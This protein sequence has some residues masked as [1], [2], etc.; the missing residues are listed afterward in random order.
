MQKQKYIFKQVM[1]LGAFLAL[2]VLA[3]LSYSYFTKAQVPDFVNY[4]GRL[5]DSSGNP[6][7]TP[8]TIQFSLYT[9]PV[10]GSPTDTPSAGGYLLWTETYDGS[11]PNCQQITPGTDGIFAQHLGECVHFPDYL[12]FTQQYYLGVKIG[13]DAEATPRVPL[14]THPYAFTSKRLYAEGEDIFIT[15]VS[16][17]NIVLQS[18][19]DILIHDTNN[20]VGVAGEI[21]SSTG[22]GLDWIS[23]SSLSA[24]SL[25]DTDH[26]TGIQV[27]ESADEDV[28][29]MDTAGAQR[30]MLDQQGNLLLSNTEP[31]DLS[32]P[33]NLQGLLFRNNKFALRFGE[34]NNN[35][36]NDANIGNGSFAS[37]RNNIVSGNYSSALGGGNNINDVYSVALGRYHTVTGSY[38]VAGGYQNTA[39]GYASS[40][41][42]QT[43]QATDVRAMAWGMNNQ[44][45][46]DEATAFGYNT[47]ATGA[48]SLSFGRNTVASGAYATAF[49]YDTTASNNYSLAFGRSTI[50]GN[51]Y[52][53]AWGNDTNATGL[54]A[55]AFGYRTTASGQYT[56]A[57]GYYSEASGNNAVALNDTVAN[58]YMMTAVGRFNVVDSNQSSD[59]WVDTDYLFVVGNGT[60]YQSANRRNALTI[61]KNGSMEV[62]APADGATLTQQP[63]GNVDLA[64]A[65]TGYVNDAISD[66]ALWEQVGYDGTNN[67]I[68]GGDT[69]RNKNSGV[70]GIV[71]HNDDNGINTIRLINNND[72]DNYAGSALVLKG[73]GADYRNQLYFGVFGN[74]FYQTP[75]QNK[76]ILKTRDKDLWIGTHTDGTQNIRFFSDVDDVTYQPDWIGTFNATGVYFNSL[77]TLSSVPANSGVIMS[78]LTTGQLV[79]VDPGTFTNI[80]TADGT[81]SSERILDGNGNLYGLNFSELSEFNVS[82]TN[83]INL[84][85]LTDANF[86]A[87]DFNIGS[88]ST[89]TLDISNGNSATFNDHRATP[90][91]VEYG[92]D[93]SANY[94]ARSLVDKAYVDS[95]VGTSI[96]DADS[97]TGIQ[98]EASPDEDYI[99]MQTAGSE[100]FIIDNNGN[101]GI[102]I[103][104]NPL[105]SVLQIGPGT[106]EASTFAV[107]ANPAYMNIATFRDQDGENIFRARGSLA[108]DDLIVTFG[109]WDW[110]YDH[111][112]FGINTT[113]DSLDFYGGDF[114]LHEFAGSQSDYVGFKAPNDVASSVVW[115][116]PS[117][118]GNN[119]YLLQTDGA[120]NLSW[121]NPST[122]NITNIYNSNGTLT[123]DRSVDGGMHALSFNNLNSTLFEITDGASNL[124]TMELTDSEFLGSVEDGTQNSGFGIQADEIYLY[125]TENTSGNTFQLDISDTNA[126]IRDDIN[127]RGIEYLADYSANYTDRTLV[128][129][130]YVDS[131]VS[132]SSFWVAG[133]SGTFSIRTTGNTASGG[134]ATGNYSVAMGYNTSASTY[135]AIAEGAA[136][137]ANGEGSHAEGRGSRAQGHASH[138]EG[139][140]SVAGGYASHAE[141]LFTQANGS[142]SH[143]EGTGT[144]AQNNYQFAGGMYNVGTAN[145]TIME[146]GIGTGTSNRMNAFEIYTDGSILAPEFSI[147]EINARGN[148]SLTT[149]EYVDN[150]IATNANNIYNNDGTISEDRSIAGTGAHTVDFNMTDGLIDSGMTYNHTSSELY[151]QGGGVGSRVSVNVGD[152]VTITDLLSN[153]GA[154][155]AADYSANYTNRSLVDKEYVDN[156]VASASPW[157]RDTTNGYIYQKFLTDRVGIGTATP[158]ES[159]VVY[160]G[161]AKL[162]RDGVDPQII[163]EGR[164]TGYNWV[165]GIDEE[166]NIGPG[167]FYIGQGA[168]VDDTNALLRLTEDGN[169][170]LDNT[171]QLHHGTQL[172]IMSDGNSNTDSMLFIGAASD[173]AYPRIALYRAKNNSTSEGGVVANDI[174]GQIGFIGR[175]STTT[176]YV[177][178]TF[179][180]AIATETWT[181]TAHGAALQ[182]QTSLN[183][184]DAPVRRLEIE[185]DGTLNVA[186]TTDYELLVTDDDDIPNKAYVDTAIANNSPWTKNGTNLSPTTA[187]DD[188]LLNA[189]ETLSISDLTQG[190][191]PFIGAGGLFSQDNNNFFWDDTNDRLGLGTSTP[192][193]RL[194]VVG[195]NI[196][197]D[198]ALVARGTGTNGEAAHLVVDAEA[199]TLHRLIEARNNNGIQFVVNG[200]NRV[201]IG[202]SNPGAPLHIRNT[203]DNSGAV[204]I[205]Q[206]TNGDYSSIFETA[207]NPEGNI[208][209]FRGDLAIDGVNGN[210][211]IKND[212]DNTNTGWVRLLEEGDLTALWDA[213]SDTGI[214]VEES[215]DEDMIRFDTAGTQRM[216][217]D[218]NGL[219]SYGTEKTDYDL[220]YFGTQH[221]VFVVNQE[222][223]AMSTFTAVKYGD[224]GE[225]GR[226]SFLKARGSEGVETAV[227]DGDEI[228]EFATAAYDGTRYMTTGGL[229]V[230][231]DGTVGTDNVPSKLEFLTNPGNDLGAEVTMV[232]NHDGNLGIGVTDPSFKLE[233]HGDV[234]PDSSSYSLGSDSKRW[235]NLYLSSSGG[236]NIGSNT[237]GYSNISYNTSVNRLTLQNS[238]DSTNGFQF[239]D[240]DGGTPILSIDTTDE[241]VGIGTASPAYKLTISGGALMLEDSPAPTASQGFAGIYTSSGELYA[242]DDSGNST[243]ISPHNK[244][245]EWWYNSTNVKTG[246]TLQIEMERLMRELN[247]TFGGGYIKENGQEIDLGE[248]VLDVLSLKTNQNINTLSGL[249]KNVNHNLLLI[250]DSLKEINKKLKTN[251]EN[252]EDNENNLKTLSANINSLTELTT[253]L[254]NTLSNHEERISK[255]ENILKDNGI[256]PEQEET[257]ELPKVLQTFADN[258]K[259][260]QK[261]GKKVEFTLDGKLVV[262]EIESDKVKTKELATD[263]LTISDKNNVGTA[264]IKKGKEKV[265]VDTKKVSDSS[266][267]ILT[268]HGAV[269]VGVGKIK[270]GES[271]EIVLAKE[272]E[273][274]IKVEWLL[275]NRE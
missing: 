35:E 181:N 84:E 85:S 177:A 9:D 271:F 220:A 268:P 166:E 231:V 51:D 221:S 69:L 201:G 80:Y 137:S 191:I 13:S 36:W 92:A 150:A 172:S 140:Q 264:T 171:N 273:E 161:N 104:N 56:L 217:I 138:A 214:Q 242:F 60:G 262:Q 267:I 269:V 222:P 131:L 42:G 189:G 227:Q 134:D 153:R 190:S 243:Q 152:Y 47:Q 212:N 50:A 151:H 211:Y 205:L 5:R 260:L 86:I 270:K 2:S 245:G 176:D 129:K 102:G 112:S 14:S 49:G 27:E 192:S 223:T 219:L 145:D 235:L 154:V 107:A 250:N 216:R 33:G 255:L 75:F 184:T 41:F 19:G 261:D 237:L 253:N 88:N 149:K 275:V 254:T 78:D 83:S 97:D 103:G 163:L 265:T 256:N 61:L 34:T 248:N 156:Q 6:I 266:H 208:S 135:Y 142:G 119:G 101:T 72:T 23:P 238:V 96:F 178:S 247:K 188:I 58:S 195:G 90:R 110:A 193:S 70:K 59:T 197:T 165:M 136:T 259:A 16:S 218:N 116:L 28:I 21:L 10:H 183:G 109:D 48:R 128:D 118:D 202:S 162:S 274:D 120:G 225:P 272:A 7:T 198:R 43:N 164:D 18:A 31:A 89:M 187:G 230:K 215:A 1:K 4:Q 20:S 117:S 63:T 160:D 106:S 65:T 8:V 155:Y 74:S 232:L 79:A 257:A 185:N 38:A 158:D 196:Q 179:I 194:D 236:L 62:N 98:V 157:F 46:A 73:S 239:L 251:R 182:F 25:W 121:T 167:F 26:D 169:L 209:A 234:G 111:L 29:R 30:F 53:V 11:S 44:A 204:I 249:Q 3:F 12:D 174:L 186:G 144:I 91:G 146:V 246:Q 57:T 66:N 233:V 210:I 252:I 228:A 93:Y 122:L 173:S 15:T 94:T 200:N 207:T 263:Q 87:P 113:T 52:A 143:S 229:I 199:S 141:G 244:N 115:T 180:N 127:H 77:Q 64:I 99:R 240:A 45:T 159:L 213:D 82:D 39:G 258:L 170:F 206:N 37:G 175:N 76:A 147:A 22:N 40:V 168:N 241:R 17:G 68:W 24:G 224:D 54:G 95:H 81:L 148:T 55:T 226:I 105:V 124:T 108:N 71:F 125:Y 133:S 139:Q 114:R 203:Q 132:S 123:G 126:T 67:T 130:G 32:N 100:R